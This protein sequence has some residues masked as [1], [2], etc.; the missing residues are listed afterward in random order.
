[1]FRTDPKA[2]LAEQVKTAEWDEL[3][4]ERL[5]L[6]YSFDCFLNHSIPSG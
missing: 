6:K 5:I 2:P 4:T 1:M 3:F